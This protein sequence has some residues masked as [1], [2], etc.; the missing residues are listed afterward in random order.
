MALEAAA[1][2]V[3][4]LVLLEMLLPVLVLLVLNANS[5]VDVGTGCVAA[6]VDAFVT[7]AP[8]TTSLLYHCCVAATAKT[9]GTWSTTTIVKQT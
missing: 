6:S 9:A 4:L 1:A 3:V 8:E 2:V 7:K 5:V